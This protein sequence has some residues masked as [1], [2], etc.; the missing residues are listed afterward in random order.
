M[1]QCDDATQWI[2]VRPSSYSPY[3][4]F[5]RKPGEP[6]TQANCDTPI[7]SSRHDSAVYCRDSSVRGLYEHERFTFA[8]MATRNKAGE[9]FFSFSSAVSNKAFKALRHEV[10]SWRI[11]RWNNADLSVLACG[12]SWMMGSRWAERFASGNYER[13][14]ARL[15]G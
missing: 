14:A 7:G 2:T 5:G 13:T 9:P 12:S 11:H 1:Q 3:I 15:P 8:P 4:V 10:R 6:V